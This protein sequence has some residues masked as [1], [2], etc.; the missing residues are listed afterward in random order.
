M[1]EAVTYP[2]VTVVDRDRATLLLQVDTSLWVRRRFLVGQDSTYLA[3]PFVTQVFNRTQT[4]QEGFD[5]LMPKA[6]REAIGQG[7]DVKRQGDWF[8]VPCPRPP[9]KPPGLMWAAYLKER[10]GDAF[11]PKVLYS[12]QTPTRHRVQGYSFYGY[13]GYLAGEVVYRVDSRH[14]VRGIVQAP[15]HPDLRLDEWH[16]AIRQRS[17]PWGMT[18]GQGG[19]D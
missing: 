5:S 15:D 1:D 6:V 18:S 14:A 13:P 3:P 8:F 9:A 10:L 4:V 7:L 19:E 2:V 12:N 16:R 17:G 11:D